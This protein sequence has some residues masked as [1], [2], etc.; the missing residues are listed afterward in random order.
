VEGV[1]RSAKS[2]ARGVSSAAGLSGGVSNPRDSP[3]QF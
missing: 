2:D 1:S 3:Y